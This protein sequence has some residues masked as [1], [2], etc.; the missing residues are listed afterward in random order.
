METINPLLETHVILGWII[1]TGLLGFSHILHLPTFIHAN[2]AHGLCPADVVIG[3]VIILGPP[4]LTGFVMF[5]DGVSRLGVGN[6]YV[7]LGLRNKNIE[8][9]AAITE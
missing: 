5:V 1:G 8:F 3:M 4:V 2:V 6:L 9:V 7:L